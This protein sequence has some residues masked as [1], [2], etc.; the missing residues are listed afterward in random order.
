MPDQFPPITLS[1]RRFALAWQAVQQA[2]STEPDLLPLYRTTLIERHIDG[3]MLVSTD[4]YLM[5]WAWV[6]EVG[7]GADDPEAFRPDLDEVPLASV[8]VC[9]EAQLTRALMK[10]I[11]ASTKPQGGG[12]PD[13]KAPIDLAVGTL[14]ALAVEGDQPTLGSVFDDDRPAVVMASFGAMTAA[15]IIAHDFPDWR[16]LAQAKPVKS[17]SR[18][19]LNA[20]YLAR[21]G[22]IGVDENLAAV[23]L[24]FLGRSG[25]IAVDIPGDPRISGR[26]MPL[27]EEAAPSDQL[28]PADDLDAD[29]RAAAERLA[30]RPADPGE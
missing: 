24:S 26:W 29:L 17:A 20:K 30:E 7:A 6:P 16:P 18:V 28:A 13:R 3:V 2:A 12:Q 15:P 22:A 4:R 5:L 14:G 8:L 1:A 11:K 23:W 25:G 9:D 21:V 10:H 19:G 27:V